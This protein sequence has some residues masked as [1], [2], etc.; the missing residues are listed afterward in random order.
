MI[1]N[2][3]PGRMS[4]YTDA[5]RRFIYTI[6]AAC[7]KNCRKGWRNGGRGGGGGGGF[8]CIKTTAAKL[9]CMTVCIGR[10]V[11]FAILHSGKCPLKKKKK[12]KE[13]EEEV[14][15]ARMHSITKLAQQ[16]LTKPRSQPF[17][18][19][20]LLTWCL[21]HLPPPPSAPSTE[22]IHFWVLF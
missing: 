19:N 12:K 10:D 14:E 22:P 8:L 9:S 17:T 4:I 15:K 6:H 18:T 5:G 13:E 20:A 2:Q 7:V 1:Q 21:Q 16:I 3:P 11:K